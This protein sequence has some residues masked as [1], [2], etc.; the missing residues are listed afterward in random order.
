MFK[1][2]SLFL[3]FVAMASASA[4]D[5]QAGLHNWG[6]ELTTVVANFGAGQPNQ[7]AFTYAN[8]DSLTVEGAVAESIWDPTC[9]TQI[10][11]TGLASSESTVTGLLTTS[12][13]TVD[14]SSLGAAVWSTPTATTGQ[15]TFCYRSEILIEGHQMNYVDTILTAIVDI[16]NDIP[17]VTGLTVADKDATIQDGLTAA[18]NY[19]LTA[20][21]CDGSNVEVAPVPAMV[22]GGSL[23]I[24]IGLPASVAGVALASVYDAKL[25]QAVTLIESQA[26]LAGVPQNTFTSTSCPTGVLCTVQ[27]TVVGSFF[28]Q[29]GNALSLTGSCIMAI[30]RRMLEVPMPSAVRGARNMEGKEA[31]EGE[32]KG[33]FDVA[34]PLAADEK[35]DSSASDSSSVLFAAATLFAFALV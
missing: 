23:K 18:I 3:G 6:Y 4:R 15:I 27:T 31:V 25:S 14:F 10:D 2:A 34:V 9:T 22:P 29:D 20:V 26:I 13:V 1:T 7:F 17:T 21:V 5:L 33:E 28:S 19:P 32:G 30:G 8:G 11:V 16:E 35:S 12:T 24:C